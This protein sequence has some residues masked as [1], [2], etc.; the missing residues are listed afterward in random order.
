M[1]TIAIDWDHT[2]TAAP[3]LFKDFID[4]AKAQGHTVIVITGRQSSDSVVPPWPIEIV[5]AGSEWKKTAA[6]NAGY[7]VDIWIDDQPGHIEPCR[8]LQW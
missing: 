4:L 2:I 5:Y 6:K 8:K 1:L 3:G 7:I